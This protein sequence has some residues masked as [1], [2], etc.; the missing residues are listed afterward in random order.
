MGDL[1]FSGGLYGLSVGNQQFTSR[2]L[3]FNN[4]NTAINQFWD[5]G[6]TYQGLS[7][8]NCKIGIAMDGGA[9]NGLSVSSM[10]VVDSSITN[11]PIFVKTG[12]SA[13]AQPPAANAV[14]LEN[15]KISN[16]PTV[17]QNYQGVVA[18]AGTTGSATVAAWGQGSTSYTPN[19]PTAI[20]GNLPV[21]RPSALVSNG[22]YFARSKPQYTSYT[23]SQIVSAR[24]QGAKGDGVTDDTAALQR[25]IMTAASSGKLLYI[26]H[27]DYLVS[28]TIYIPSG[29]RIVGETFP[30]I[31]SYGSFFNDINNPQPVVQ[32]GKPGESGWVS[33]SDTIVSTRGGQAGAVL[34][35]YNLAATMGAPGGLWD[36]HTRIGGFAGSQLQLAQC[37]KT[38]NVV[39]TAANIPA[40]CIA[41]FM[42][43]HATKGSAA[44]HLENVW[45][46]V[47]D[48][49][50]EDANQS[51]ITVY[52]GRGFLDESTNGPVWLVGTSSEHHV[53]YQYQLSNTKNVYAGQIQTE[54]A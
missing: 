14:I 35:Q 12:R 49:D 20:Q 11:T 2:N 42:S 29:S 53:M 52:A 18:L 41:A 32:V 16:V 28:K 21:S 3:V 45:L 33:W 47:A 48:H 27:G 9:P 23:T 37:P 6:W 25:A 5:W 40:N 54:T 36:V 50:V 34:I 15:I 7:I 38:P 24:S 4:V 39:A 26:D 30:V 19:G 1:T 13:S 46:W 10:T 22:N 31:L 17:V 8:N 44:L 51:Q 43:L